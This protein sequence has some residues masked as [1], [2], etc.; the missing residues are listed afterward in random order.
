M[1]GV[2]GPV[3][4]AVDEKIGEQKGCVGDPNRLNQQ[5]E[6]KRRGVTE[7]LVKKTPKKNGHAGTRQYNLRGEQ[8]LAR[9]DVHDL[10]QTE[11]RKKRIT[12]KT[13]PVNVQAKKERQPRTKL[14]ARAVPP[15][16]RIKKKGHRLPPKKQP[17]K[18]P[19]NRTE[20]RKRSPIMTSHLSQKP[21]K[22]RR[23]RRP[24]EKQPKR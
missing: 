15:T 11:K 6:K 18:L 5:V 3:R 8:K 10:L 21:Q 19:G 1:K 24:K 9:V 7:R 23:T 14:E 12:L 2:E 13:Y 20:H 16:R 4:G 22:R 17:E